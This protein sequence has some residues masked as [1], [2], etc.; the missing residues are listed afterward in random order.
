MN[1]VQG[2]VE[3]WGACAPTIELNK[4]MRKGQECIMSAC[5]YRTQP[6]YILN[7]HNLYILSKHSLY[8]LSK[9]NLYILSKHSL[10]ILSKHNLYI[11]LVNTT[12]IYT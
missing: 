2:S 8:I 9:H 10:Y 1:L 11:Y 5:K 4:T 3:A 7:K 12:F 6:F